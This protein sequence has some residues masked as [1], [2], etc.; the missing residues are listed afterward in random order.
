MEPSD[1]F[2]PAKPVPGEHPG[3]AR[4]GQGAGEQFSSGFV[5]SILDAGSVK[6]SRKI[7]VLAN[8]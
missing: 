2:R 4:R 8:G 5:G 3:T 1:H 7:R 6:L